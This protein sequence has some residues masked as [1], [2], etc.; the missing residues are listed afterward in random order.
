MKSNKINKKYKSTEK[1]IIKPNYKSSEKKIIKLKYKYNEEKDIKK[2]NLFFNDIKPKYKSNE[3]KIIKPI[4]KYN[5]EK[6][7][8][9]NNFFNNI[10]QNY[11]YNEGKNI[12]KINNFVNNNNINKKYKYNEKKVI[13][14]IYKYN[15][16]KNIKKIKHKEDI[17]NINDNPFCNYIKPKDISYEKYGDDKD[18]ISESLE[19]YDI[20]KIKNILSDIQPPSNNFDVVF[21]V[22]A[23]DSMFSYIQS[24]KEETKN[25]AEDLAITYPNKNFKFGYIFYRDPIDSQYDIHEI[26]DLTNDIDS[27]ETKIDKI[28]A[29]GGGDW[30]EDW[31]GAYKLANEKITWRDGI[32]LI[33]H[34]ADDGAHGELFSKGDYY[35]E[36]E[37][38]LIR[39]LI[40]CAK[41][42]IRIFGYVIQEFCRQSFEEASKIYRKK[43]GIFEIFKF[44]QPE[45]LKDMSLDV[46]KLENINSN[47]Y[48]DYDMD[49]EQFHEMNKNCFNYNVKEAIEKNCC[50]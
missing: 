28:E 2:I 42:G 48:K 1:K 38:K 44:H 22:D 19:E 3:K 25:I 34:L 8:K 36:E 10:K 37:P 49:Y 20:K 17:S 21:L 47:N 31:A 45:V 23:T 6:N 40:K 12:K 15:E 43:G 27:I 7:I 46:D 26:I 30:P 32:K 13:K 33:I 18:Y 16:E 11:K 24:A 4:N 5:D 29:Y 9:I 14:P 35:P 50:D 39:E 41:K